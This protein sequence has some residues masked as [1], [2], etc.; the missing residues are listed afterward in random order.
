MQRVN[1][2]DLYTSQP[3][4]GKVHVVRNPVH[5]QWCQVL[6]LL[7]TLNEELLENPTV[8]HQGYFDDLARLLRNFKQRFTGVLHI[9][10]QIEGQHAN[11]VQEP[12]SNQLLSL[13]LL[14]EVELMCALLQQLFEHADLWRAHDDYMYQEM[15]DYVLFSVSKLLQHCDTRSLIPAS[16]TEEHLK[17]ISQSSVTGGDGAHGYH[18]LAGADQA[19]AEMSG[20]ELKAELCLQNIFLTFSCSILNCLLLSKKME[21]RGDPP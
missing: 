15:K 20:L 13:A 10:V 18:A 2:E 5:V 12:Q 1:S 6:L 8:E 3:S 21:L 14:E 17:T 11:R 9:G 19:L 7:R 16:V 4:G